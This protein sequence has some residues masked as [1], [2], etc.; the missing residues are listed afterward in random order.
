MIKNTYSASLSFLLLVLIFRFVIL[1]QDLKGQTAPHKKVNNKGI[2][3]QAA[4][5][6]KEGTTMKLLDDN[7]KHNP[8]NNC[9]SSHL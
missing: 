6:G 3:L 8:T 4:A 5:D 1:L 9:A 7:Q 2:R